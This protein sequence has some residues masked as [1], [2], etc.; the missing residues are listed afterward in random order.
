MNGGGEMERLAD[1]NAKARALGLT[2]GE[3]VSLH[4]SPSK[5][6]PKPQ[7]PPK[8]SKKTY[9]DETAFSLWQLG[10]SD[11]QIG[12][13]LGVSRAIIQRW[14]DTLEIP[15]NSNPLINTQKYH[16]IK[17]PYGFFVITE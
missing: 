12:A 2:Y 4:P 15:S 16:L 7:K 6:H 9:S 10:K 8:P 14:R 13:E 17:T 1:I 11:A 5:T 3:Y